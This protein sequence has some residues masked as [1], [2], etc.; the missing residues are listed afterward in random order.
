MELHATDAD[1]ISRVL[2]DYSDQGFDLADA[3]LMYLTNREGVRTV[4]TTD[5]RHF[6]VF[7]T[8]D[9]PSLA[10]IPE[11]ESMPG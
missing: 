1:G 11:A 8:N 2:S 10:L 6:A 5:R 7:R 3:T 9:G 4:F